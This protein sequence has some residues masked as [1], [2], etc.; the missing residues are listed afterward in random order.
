ERLIKEANLKSLQAESLY[1]AASRF[2][3]LILNKYPWLKESIDNPV[4][5]E[6]YKATTKDGK[7]KGDVTRLFYIDGVDMDS[8]LSGIYKDNYRRYSPAE[9]EYIG[10]LAVMNA[11]LNGKAV[12][13]KGYVKKGYNQ[14][15][16][17]VC[18]FAYGPIESRL[19]EDQKQLRDQA[20]AAR[21]TAIINA[22]EVSQ[23]INAAA[24]NVSKAEIVAAAKMYKLYADGAQDIAPREALLLNNVTVD[25]DDVKNMDAFM[26]TATPEQ[27]GAFRDYFVNA[28]KNVQ[29]DEVLDLNGPEDVRSNEYLLNKL[30]NTVKHLQ[31][32]NNSGNVA[33]PSEEV[34]NSIQAL[35]VTTGIIRD[36]NSEDPA[37]AMAASM[38]YR[39]FEP[40]IKGRSIGQI[41][42]MYPANKANKTYMSV[43]ADEYKKM[44]RQNFASL[45][46]AEAKAYQETGRL[47]D[48]AKNLKLENCYKS[49]MAIDIPDNY[50]GAQP[51]LGEARVFSAGSF[52]DTSV[53]GFRTNA[54]QSKLIRENKPIDLDFGNTYTPDYKKAAS[55]ITDR[56]KTTLTKAYRN[57][58]YKPDVS[59]EMLDEF[60]RDFELALN[61]KIV[62]GGYID[63]CSTAVYSQDLADDM[64][65]FI[66]GGKSLPY[67]ID[68]D[69]IDF[70]LMDAKNSVARKFN[71]DLG[72]NGVYDYFD[73]NYAK[74]KPELVVNT[75]LNNKLGAA[76]DFE[77]IKIIRNRADYFGDIRLLKNV[78]FRSLTENQ[79][80]IGEAVFRNMEHYDKL[81]RHSLKDPEVAADCKNSLTNLFYIDGV[82]ADKYVSD[83]VFGY[84]FKSAQEKEMLAKVA[85]A[86]AIYANN[87]NVDVKYYLRNKDGSCEVKVASVEDRRYDHSDEVLTDEESRRRHEVTR[88]I[89]KSDKVAAKI[90]E[91]DKS[92]LE[93]QHKEFI[94][95]TKL[96]RDKEKQAEKI[97]AE[98]SVK[99]RKNANVA[100]VADHKK[101]EAE[102]VK[103]AHSAELA[104]SLQSATDA[105][106]SAMQKLAEDE[107]KEITEDDFELY[108]R[109]DKGQPIDVNT[110]PEDVIPSVDGAF[111][112]YRDYD[113]DKT[114]PKLYVRTKSATTVAANESADENIIR[115]GNNA[116]IELEDSL[117]LED[118]DF[119]SPIGFAEEPRE[120]ISNDIADFEDVYD[121]D[122]DSPSEVKPQEQTIPKQEDRRG[123]KMTVN[124]EDGTL[125]A[126]DGKHKTTR[127]DN[128]QLTPDVQKQTNKKKDK[129]L[130]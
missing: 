43:V 104:K 88:N 100:A 98:N 64:N 42:A 119:K 45:T 53:N 74:D 114:N 73:T 96:F 60:C 121:F 110:P 27:M 106:E 123:Q 72:I 127:T 18:K 16:V 20:A 23:K 61:K 80:F 76:E 58:A 46:L 9:R 92:N 21:V 68:S 32:M 90:N 79:R 26:N 37:T 112:R 44:L 116:F 113:P 31:R 108:I 85:I 103:A 107:R 48:D 36:M 19:S 81:L 7:A 38:A 34:N 35:K 5:A 17:K 54:D 109:L 6:T 70:A 50:Y 128:R 89:L 99:E 29:L 28:V 125:T 86:Q 115:V 82:R 55:I 101:K 91:K 63:K 87:A 69:Y 33:K 39:Y 130:E 129:E 126:N 105:M 57:P 56:V 66:N 40:Y 59:K 10:K 8:Y 22:D 15:D 71:K 75:E 65:E 78:D 97:K 24:N 62:D 30:E 94:S 47:P 12:E 11:L 25:I 67:F 84:M 4:A 51:K 77:P 83:R 1:P 102:A 41:A 14:C 120:N 117:D 111:V 2:D 124:L 3:E 13:A 49:A 52:Y 93:K 122:L 118:Y 95:K